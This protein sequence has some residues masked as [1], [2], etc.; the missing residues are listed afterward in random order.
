MT[1]QLSIITL[2]VREIVKEDRP[3]LLFHLS[4][5]GTVVASNQSLT[6]LQL[7]ALDGLSRGYQALFHLLQRPSDARAQAEAVGSG[8]FDLWLAPYW[9]RIQGVLLPGAQRLFVIASEVATVLNLTWELMRPPGEDFV[10]FDAKLGIRRL[11]W[12]N[13][14]LGPFVGHL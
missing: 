13:G 2:A 3:E 7:H 11:P 8:L 9:D 5:S 14:T 1:G 4:V 10:G 12:S 6:P